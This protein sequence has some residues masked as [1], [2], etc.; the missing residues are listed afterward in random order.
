MKQEQPR[1]KVIVFER[2][3]QVD[4]QV[5]VNLLKEQGKFEYVEAQVFHMLCEET[6][7]PALGGVVYL[8]TDPEVCMSRIAA[9]SRAGEDCLTAEYVS[10]CHDHHE[11]WLRH[12]VASG[13][14]TLSIDANASATYDPESKED[15]GLRWV[16]RAKEFISGFLS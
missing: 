6:P 15:L 8:S 5:F 11:R 1:C 3:M 2:S 10:S 14:K 12:E 7:A 13:T 9:R 4:E 16:E